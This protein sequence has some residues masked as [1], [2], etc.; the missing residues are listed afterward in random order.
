M[1]FD[2]KGD[3]GLAEDLVFFLSNL[4]SIEDHAAK[5][6][7]LKKDTKWLE[8]VEIIRTM[9]TKWLSGLVKKNNSHI[10]CI[11]KHLL[12][13]IEGAIEVGNRFVSTGQHEQASEAYS[14]ANSLTSLLL[15]LNGY[16]GGKNVS[17]AK[18]SA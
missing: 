4:T 18:S 11:S 13:S 9:R 16:K 10:W 15:V 2:K 5:S 17:K 6:Y 14:D 12:S 1:G 3:V 7:P 8:V